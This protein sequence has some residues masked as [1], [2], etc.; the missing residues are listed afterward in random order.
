MR[1]RILF[2]AVPILLAASSSIAAQ[3]TAESSGTTSVKAEE[4]L[5]YVVVTDKHHRSVSDLQPSDLV[6][7][8]NGQ[9]VT[10]SALRPAG[11]DNASE[12]LVTLVFDQLS[13]TASTVARAVADR[14][15]NVGLGHRAS[16][17][18]LIAAS[19]L[20]LLTPYTTD[21]AVLSKAL[22][23]ASHAA[24]PETAAAVTAAEKQLLADAQSDAEP[25]SERARLLIAAIQQSRE[26][27]QSQHVAPALS[28]LTALIRAEGRL[29]GRKAVVYFSQGLSTEFKTRSTILTVIDEANRAGV[30]LF[31]IDVNAIDAHAGQRL[32]SLMGV[33]QP[34]ATVSSGTVS[35][36]VGAP[37]LGNTSEIVPTG[38]G[39]AANEHAGRLEFSGHDV[40]W[41]WNPLSELAEGTG[42]IYIGTNPSGASSA[43]GL[44]LEKQ[45]DELRD[46]LTSYY[47]AVYTPK[48]ERYDGQFRPV[49]VRPVRH[50][51]TIHARSGYLALPP[52]TG[53]T[54]AASGDALLS[55]FD[56]P[57]L[58][59]ELTFRAAL[60]H[61][62]TVGGAAT[63]EVVVEAPVS[64]LTVRDDASTGLASVHA[65]LAAQI[66]DAKGN[67]VESFHEELAR[68][69]AANAL[70]A[71]PAA[72]LTLQRHFSA[73]PGEYVL[74]TAVQDAVTGKISAQ[75]TRFSLGATAEGPALSDVVLVRGAEPAA[76]DPLD[77]LRYNGGRI[78]PSLATELDAAAPLS[79]FF[80]A[81]GDTHAADAP[82]LRLALIE[83]ETLLGESPLETPAHTGA[84]PFPLM[85]TVKA[86][87]LQPGSYRAQVTLTQ[88]GRSVVRSASFVIPGAAPETAKAAAPA[89]ARPLLAISRVQNP[90]AKPAETEMARWIDTA[91]SHSADYSDTLPNFYCVETIN[92][93]VDAQGR[94]E[95]KHEDSIVELVQYHDHLEHR[96]P[97]EINGAQTHTSHE[98]LPGVKSLGEFGGVLRAVF[99]PAVAATF[100]WQE[101]DILDGEPLQVFAY[102][103]PRTHS[104]FSLAGANN[105]QL[106]VGYHGQVYLD[107]ATGGVRRITME[108]DG[109]PADFSIASASI[110]VDY[111]YVSINAHDYL[112]PA[113]GSMSLREGKKRAM[114]N[115]F[116]FR[117]YRRYGSH[118]RI[119]ADTGGELLKD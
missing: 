3:T 29:P 109:L 111:S 107:A 19:R 39:M 20:S 84:E 14:M 31:P 108:A 69:A 78:V 72:A 82:Q 66:R 51:L 42:G 9:P 116:D 95:W 15:L 13:A 55:V 80:L 49:T 30:S 99:S 97:V 5:L 119:T 27:V 113:H 54:T 6:V 7:T 67:I 22:D 52:D 88:G 26:L 118:I 103:V 34:T 28:E 40:S 50:G 25:G 71:E 114:L 101:T 45:L 115:E 63:G 11:R 112:M 59:N 38:V 102:T 57:Q 83:D 117:D 85:A 56:K 110:A 23:Q 77:P 10:L 37:N 100:Q 89:A 92:R 106:V 87:T 73:L 61:L 96:T 43:E 104:S 16:M 18:V 48:I 62:G 94:G 76:S 17:A 46:N 12:Q 90:I 60:L 36:G 53:R 4:V 81:S 24:R 58:P 35:T 74:E 98:D 8:D 105:R 65:T 44:S 32:L 64:Q 21:H 70:A 93:S 41:N 68:R 79:F 2:V 91:R 75:R 86:G 1:A 47:E 33:T